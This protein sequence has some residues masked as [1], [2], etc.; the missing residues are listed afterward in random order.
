MLWL[1]LSTEELNLYV[2]LRPL[3]ATDMG[4]CVSNIFVDQPYGFGIENRNGKA[5]LGFPSQPTWLSSNNAV[6]GMRH[7]P[8]FIKRR[9]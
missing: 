9:I 7:P 2:M 6:L 1:V 8:L 3:I 5:L 4:K